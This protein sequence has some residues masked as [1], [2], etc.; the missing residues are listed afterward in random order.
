VETQY[1]IVTLVDRRFGLCTSMAAIQQRRCFLVKRSGAFD[2][3][4]ALR[5]GE[6]PMLHGTERSTEDLSSS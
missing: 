4:G 2:L 6:L 3:G 5:H 1:A